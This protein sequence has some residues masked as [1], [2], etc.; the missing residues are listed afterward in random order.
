MLR[1]CRKGSKFEHM[2]TKTEP[3]K[4]R[5]M[6]RVKGLTMPRWKMCKRNAL[7]GMRYCGQHD[8]GM[9]I[10]DLFEQPKFTRKLVLRKPLGESIVNT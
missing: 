1:R 10:A 2:D 9:T 7:S 4:C 6:V 3:R 5:K 8:N